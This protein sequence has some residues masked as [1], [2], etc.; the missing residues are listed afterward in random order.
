MRWLGLGLALVTLDA[1]SIALGPGGK[2][3]LLVF[4]DMQGEYSDVEGRLAVG[5]NLTLQHY[6][7]GM[8]LG[9]GA[10]F[11][12]TLIVGGH[13]K[14]EHGRVYHGNAVSS[15]AAL[16][17]VGFYD[18]DPATPTGRLRL[19]SALNFTALSQDM[20]AR[21]RNWASLSANGEIRIDGDSV[22]WRL[23]LKGQDSRLNVFALTTEL[24]TGTDTF[25]L[26][27][28][29]SSTVLINVAGHI[30][31]LSSFGFF[32]KVDSNW[33]RVP[34][35]SDSF[36]HDGSLTRRVLFNFFSAE[37]LAIHAIGVKGS[38]LAPWADVVF[39][40]GHI[41]GQLIAKSLRGQPG[42]AT[43]QVNWYPFISE[44]KTLWLILLPLVW[45]IT[46]SRQ[47]APRASRR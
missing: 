43:G 4:E 35:N 34:D 9:R 24:L 12:D 45:L 17:H 25:Y 19:G 3:N 46:R 2:F 38:I 20:R 29:L 8:E 7:V 26:D 44:P 10:D 16:S 33:L 6:A 36:R 14:F 13:L 18:Q 1:F 39:Y 40:D 21:S 15:S 5:G 22:N 37:A 23:Y 31:E 47:T 11:S 32:R 28:P 30:G 42:Q 27:V 41:D